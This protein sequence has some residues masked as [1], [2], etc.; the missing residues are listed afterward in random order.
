MAEDDLDLLRVANR[1]LSNLLTMTSQ[2][3]NSG[4]QAG[5]EGPCPLE[6][7]AQRMSRLWQSQKSGF[8]GK[9]GR[10]A[11]WGAVGVLIAMGKIR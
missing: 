6:V 5:V 4:E 2:R 3:E 7:S 8:R 1:M 11:F 10:R 9:L